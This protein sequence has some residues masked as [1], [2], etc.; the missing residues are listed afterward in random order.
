MKL[1]S[2]I[3]RSERLEEVE[4]ALVELEI[5]DVTVSKVSGFA[6]R[7]MLDRKELTPHMRIDVVLPESLADTVAERICEAACTGLPGDG[8]VLVT[9][10]EKVIKIRT[11]RYQRPAQEAPAG[12]GPA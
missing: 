10:V 4:E 12:E 5:P 8:I 11:R 9:P 2:A 7:R 3:V 1:V 6:G